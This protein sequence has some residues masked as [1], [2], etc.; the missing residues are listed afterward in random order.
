M[1]NHPTEKVILDTVILCIHMTHC[2][3]QMMFG[4]A[5]LTSIP[6]LF[7]AYSSKFKMA[8]LIVLGGGSTVSPMLMA[9][10]LFESRTMISCLFPSA[11]VFWV[12]EQG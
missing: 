8:I 2:R 5:A 9:L 3:T 10:L 11:A 1:A 6:S 7:K 12:I 4:R